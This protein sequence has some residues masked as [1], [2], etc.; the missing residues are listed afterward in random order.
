MKSSIDKLNELYDKLDGVVDHIY[1]QPPE[2]QHLEYPCIILNRSYDLVESAVDKPYTR[3]NGI[4]LQ[5]IDTDLSDISD[6]IYERLD[7]VSLVSEFTNDGLYHT[8]YRI[9]A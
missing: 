1:I 6:E 7:Y 3:H 9:Y 5:Y 2:G 4:D 8:Q